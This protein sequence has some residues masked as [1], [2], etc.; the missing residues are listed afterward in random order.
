MLTFPDPS[1]STE[2]TD[3]NGSVW[4][5]NGTGWVRQPESSGGGGEDFA[6]PLPSKPDVEIFAVAGGNGRPD[7]TNF[8]SLFLQSDPATGELSL[9]ENAVLSENSD[10]LKIKFAHQRKLFATIGRNRNVMVYSYETVPATLV[11]DIVTGVNVDEFC[12]G[13]TDEVI[14]IGNTTGRYRAYKESGLGNNDWSGNLFSADT[15]L[16]PRCYSIDACKSVG[17]GTSVYFLAAVNNSSM[18]ANLQDNIYLLEA[19]SSGVREVSKFSRSYNGANGEPYEVHN[20]PHVGGGIWCG[21]QAGGRS[22][23]TIYVLTDRDEVKSAYMG[24]FSSNSSANMNNAVF[25]PSGNYAFISPT[26]GK[27]ES[28]LLRVSPNGVLTKVWGDSWGRGTNRA[29]WSSDERFMYVWGDASST[30]PN[31]ERYAI[32]TYDFN[33]GSPTPSSLPEFYLNANPQGSGNPRTFDRC[34]V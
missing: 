34:R 1:V 8:E 2:Y 15:A 26:S 33:D 7:G 25:S 5:F 17:S 30:G 9:R 29:Q 3:P 4:E 11:D 23:G 19:T 10:T 21:K 16:T 22:C 20:H 12:W 14:V 6:W 32:K 13:P 27:D 18:T 24:H 31:G 28:T